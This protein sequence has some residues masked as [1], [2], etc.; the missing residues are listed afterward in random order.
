MLL[1][2]HG[3]SASCVYDVPRMTRR[4][5]WSASATFSASAELSKDCPGL[6]KQNECAPNASSIGPGCKE[7]CATDEPMTMVSNCSPV[8]VA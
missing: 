8:A 3:S 4:T 1:L 5:G 7:S 6:A 2:A